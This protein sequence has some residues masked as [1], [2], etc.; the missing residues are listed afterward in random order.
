MSC[1]SEQSASATS[2]SRSTNIGGAKS[3]FPNN[4]VPC[5]ALMAQDSSPGGHSKASNTFEDEV[6][7]Y[8]ALIEDLILPLSQLLHFVFIHKSCKVAF[9][10][11]ADIQ[12]RFLIEL[13]PRNGKQNITN[14]L[15]LDKRIRRMP[16]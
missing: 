13:F 2:F 15:G 7:G 11:W 6:S 12:E 16:S 10:F 4:N 1:S 9:M 3:L 14:G 8:S 5:L